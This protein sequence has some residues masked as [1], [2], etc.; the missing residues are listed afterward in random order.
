ME[1]LKKPKGKVETRQDFQVQCK[2]RPASRLPLG[3]LLKPVGNALL[4][5]AFGYYG[6]NAFYGY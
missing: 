3:L 6:H 2:K 4:I 1:N 5:N